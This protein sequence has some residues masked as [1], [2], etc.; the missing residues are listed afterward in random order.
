M[1]SGDEMFSLMSFDVLLTMIILTDLAYKYLPPSYYEDWTIVMF[2]INT[3]L[4]IK[5]IVDIVSIINE[6]YPKNKNRGN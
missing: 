1:V 6:K 3:I 2:I 4:L 5:V